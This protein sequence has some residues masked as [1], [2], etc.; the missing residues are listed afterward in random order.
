MTPYEY[1]QIGIAIFIAIGGLVAWT[2]RHVRTMKQDLLKDIN[3]DIRVG[4]DK[5]TTAFNNEIARAK[6]NINRMEIVI[7][8]HREKFDQVYERII[9]LENTTV[10]DDKV[11]SLIHEVIEDNKQDMNKIKEILTATIESIDQLKI[12]IAVQDA[13]MNNRGK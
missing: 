13:I 7:A 4:D 12:S 5:A 11:R 8:A 9:R 3:K 2:I 1:F 10:S 6:D